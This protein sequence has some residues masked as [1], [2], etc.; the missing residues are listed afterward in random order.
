MIAGQSAHAGAADEVQLAVRLA[1][2]AELQPVELVIVPAIQP[3][4][5]PAEMPATSAP[6][7]SPT[8]GPAAL[9]PGDMATAPL[10]DRAVQAAPAMMHQAAPEAW[11]HLPADAV[12]PPQAGRHAPEDAG[13]NGA[14]GSAMISQPGADEFR[15]FDPQAQR[16]RRAPSRIRQRCSGAPSSSGSP[17]ACSTGSRRPRPAPM[18]RQARPGERSPAC[19]LRF[20]LPWDADA[21]LRDRRQA[22]GAP[23]QRPPGSGVCWSPP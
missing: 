9:P 12:D 17:P 8:S 21:A 2:G 10:A 22:Y 5:T 1:P 11:P 3:K 20:W 14:P 15:A 18:Q 6:A 7:R 4:S 23:A 13:E 19:R 16:R